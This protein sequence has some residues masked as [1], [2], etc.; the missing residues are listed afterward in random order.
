VTIDATDGPSISR[1]LLIGLASIMTV[2]F[3]TVLV[4]VVVT[5][6]AYETADLRN[7]SVA[8]ADRLATMLESSLWNVDLEHA[9][10]LGEAYLADR[11]IVS[12]SIRDAVSGR[13]VHLGDST[14]TDTLLVRR[15]VLHGTQQVGTIDL[16]FN[17]RAYRSQLRA[18]VAVAVAISFIVL[19]ISLI[20]LRTLVRRLLAKPL[21]QLSALVTEFSRGGYVATEPRQPVGTGEL[22]HLSAVLIDM[23]A[24]ISKQ[25]GA[26]RE[27]SAALEAA[28]NSICMVRRSG[29][30]MW[31]NPAFTTLTGY[32]SEEAV[33][34]RL[35]DLVDA[36]VHDTAFFD[37][38]RKIIQAG[39]VWSGEVTARRKNGSTWVGER[40][41]TPLCGSDG[42]VTH[43]VIV[44]QDVTQRKQLEA[45]YR[46]AQKME[47]V[48]RLAGGIA[49][50]FNNMLSVIVGNA[51]LAL[52]Q[53]PSGTPL[54]DD[55]AEIRRAAQ[56]STELTRQL[57]A[58]ARKQDVM[59]QPL[60]L[61][62]VVGKSLRMLQRMVGAQIRFTFSPGADL[63]RVLM[64]PS[65]LDQVL[66]NLCVNARDAMGDTG[67]ITIT[68]Q[69][70][71]LDAA[72]CAEHEGLPPGDYVQLSVNDTGSG[73]PP[74]VVAQIFEPFFTTK[75]LG[76]GT[77]LGLST[78]YGIVMQNRGTICVSSTVGSGTRFDLYFPRYEGVPERAAPAASAIASPTGRETI[79]V[80]DDEPMVLTMAERVLTSAGYRVLSTSTPLK[81]IDV[82]RKHDG[83][84]DLL[85]CD[86]LMPER[87]GYD[88]ARDL[89]ALRPSL[90][91]I[92][93]SGYTGAGGAAPPAAGNGARHLGKPFPPATL[94]AAVRQALDD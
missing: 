36:G 41:V 70:C 47:S 57:L 75:A 71:V 94:L 88:V 59:P 72:W 45:Q 73:M 1:R 66:A 28:A 16:A 53:L 67:T 20:G 25:L 65:Q 62:E 48:G 33:G 19:V 46:Q 42:V 38:I 56:R 13:V 52:S 7:D 87:T 2:T 44:E 74:E 9:Q 49:H 54:H 82:A 90:K 35:V 78:V 79:L 14:A 22:H 5:L 21:D 93:M 15:P 76:D 81:A 80:V 31:I 11:R 39:K 85:L 89:L 12:I 91:C 10:E 23:G 29:E 43:Y 77:G 26:L 55:V 30:I 32:S 27:Q 69:N 8:A 18:D 86:V 64:D 24:Q 4:I 61:N 6:R 17:R 37:D 34:Q 3:L 58:F 60:D 84:I 40:T 63:W 92:F 83:P 51:D 50:D 68:T